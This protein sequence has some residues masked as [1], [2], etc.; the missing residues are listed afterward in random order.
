M[1][2][3]YVAEAVSAAGRGAAASRLARDVRPITPRGH[4]SVKPF[5]GS[6]ARL[7]CP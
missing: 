1:A 3:P 6:E 7:Q 4:V 2:V 5:P